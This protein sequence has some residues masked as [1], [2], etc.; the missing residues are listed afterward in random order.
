[1]IARLTAA[2]DAGDIPGA[3][4]GAAPAARIYVGQIDRT[5][6]VVQEYRISYD[7]EQQQDVTARG[8]WTLTEYA[9]IVEHRRRLHR[10]D[11]ATA[12]T[13]RSATNVMARLLSAQQFGSAPLHVLKSSASAQPTT[14]EDD[15]QIEPVR[16]AFLCRVETT[17]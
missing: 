2:R 8:D 12:D 3:A 9:W 15:R 13:A 7:G 6:D 1:M 11:V 17:P 16:V 14:F 4:V 10:L 5:N